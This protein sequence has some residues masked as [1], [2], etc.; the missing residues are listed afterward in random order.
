MLE[1]YSTF[2]QKKTCAICCWRACCRRASCWRASFWI[3]VWKIFKLSSKENLCHLLLKGF[4]P[5]GLLPKGLI[6]KKSLKDIQLSLKENLGYLLPK[7]LLPKGFLLNGLLL[8]KW[9][10]KHEIWL[11]SEPVVVPCL[12]AGNRN[13]K[14]E[15]YPAK[16][17]AKD[18][19]D[20]G[21]DRFDQ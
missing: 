20:P 21:V 2:L 19:T 1:R 17:I 10:T 18:T 3:N 8:K 9:V 7:G 11:E 5:E 15:G 12:S 16:N 14:A 6:L 13:H 4:P